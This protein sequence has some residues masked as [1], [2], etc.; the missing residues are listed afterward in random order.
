MAADAVEV[1][2]GR[3]LSDRA[4]AGWVRAYA[5]LLPLF[6]MATLLLIRR[7]VQLILASGVMQAIMLPMLGGAALFF[8]YRRCD[9]RLRPSIVWDLF[10]WVSSAGLLVA[11]VAGAYFTLFK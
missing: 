7:P 4:R 2:R 1:F 9:P 8:R 5:V 6:A 11:G 10:L 3:P